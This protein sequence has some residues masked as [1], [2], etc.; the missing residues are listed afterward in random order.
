MRRTLLLPALLA[1][2]TG[3]ALAAPGAG[4][5]PAGIEVVTGPAA[6]P[7]P[8]PENLAS[9]LVLAEAYAAAHPD[10]VAHP[11]VDRARGVVVLPVTAAAPEAVAAPLRA[12]LAGL[13]GLATTRAARSYA[14]LE[15]IETAAI[16][17]T[18]GDVAGAEAIVATYTDART[19]RVVVQ[20]DAAPPALLAALAARF[21][22]DA[23]VVRAIPGT[24][25]PDPQARNTDVSPFKGGANINVP[26]GGCTSGIP[27]RRNAGQRMLTAGHCA[28]AGGS[29]STPSTS[30]G[31]VTNASG[32]TW[33][34]GTGTVP[35]TGQ[36]ANRGDLA[37]IDI[38]SGKSAGT[39]VYTGGVN[40]TT[41]KNMIMMA[42]RRSAVG[43]QYCTGGAYSGEICSWSVSATGTNVSYSS[44][45]VAR[46]VV[47]GTRTPTPCT[48]NG[49]SGGPIYSNDSNNVVAK[50]VHSGGS[51]GTT[52]FGVFT[53]VW[54][55]WD[56]FGGWANDL[57]INDGDRRTSNQ[58]LQPPHYLKSP[59]GLYTLEMQHDGNLV[60]YKPSH[61]AVWATGTNT[62]ANE[63]AYAVM[64]N[65]GNFVMIRPGGVTVWST[66]TGG[67]TGAYIRLQDDCN[68]VV[69]TSTGTALWA[70]NTAGC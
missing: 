38:A 63:G 1:L 66:G 2:A 14:T 24:H 19:N 54:T 44:G 10:D 57:A 55:A 68:L 69:Y 17:L 27:W 3:A 18:L 37:R 60:I 59:N 45:E 7:L 8:L 32:E 30:M 70:S 67:H 62:A 4:A 34:S 6:V 52:C 43:D 25:R 29:V 11:W 20:T 56:A 65:D 23:V 16:D 58:L 31:T 53:D 15:R 33:N 49:D 61:I 41:W 5:A 9:A 47:T 46:N 40:S 39:A 35:L 36:T 12:R 28:P 42:T 51:A 48:T 64:Q 26:P 21:D 13:S 22:R 50:G